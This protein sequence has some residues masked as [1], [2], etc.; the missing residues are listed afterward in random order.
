MNVEEV[1]V[2]EAPL[3][4]YGGAKE[5]QKENLQRQV[6]VRVKARLILIVFMHRVD[7]TCLLRTDIWDLTRKQRPIL[8]GHNT[9]QSICCPNEK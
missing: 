4:R 3:L 8:S 6:R 5:R 2:I 9:L 1:G 7:E